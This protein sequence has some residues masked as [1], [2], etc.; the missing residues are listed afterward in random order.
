VREW[1]DQLTDLYVSYRQDTFI[2]WPVGDHP[3]EQLR[4]FA[5][6]IAPAVKANVSAQT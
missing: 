2:F 4:A 3:L 1:I 5:D 6:E